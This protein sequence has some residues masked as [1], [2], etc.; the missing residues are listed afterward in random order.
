MTAD[1]ML[2]DEAHGAAPLRLDAYYYGFDPTG[3]RA[4][5]LVLASVARAGKAYHHTESWTDAEILGES[6]AE[7]I[8]KAA[9]AAAVF[10]AAQR[11]SIAALEA[12][13]R[14]A[15]GAMIA[16]DERERT[17]G[18]KCGVPREIF[19]C[20]WPDAVAD[21]ISAMADEDACVRKSNSDLFHKVA[22]LESERDGLRALLGEFA[23]AGVEQ[24]AEPPGLDYMTIQVSPDLM[25]EARSV[26]K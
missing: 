1:E 12:D 24:E 19:G 16:Q 11:A 18:E 8:Q 2:D 4:V 14:L 17:A 26:L 5:D 3:V 23:A 9:N 25:R 6:C 7:S 13:V 15:R 21:L 10:I 22:A 20:D